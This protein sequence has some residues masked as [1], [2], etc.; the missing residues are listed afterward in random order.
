LL[1]IDRDSNKTENQGSVL[2]SNQ[3]QKNSS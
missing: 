2:D 3:E 1:G